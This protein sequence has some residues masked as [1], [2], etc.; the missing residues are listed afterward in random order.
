[1]AP[2]ASHPEKAAIKNASSSSAASFRA[3]VTASFASV[4]AAAA[5]VAA[6][7]AALAAAVVDP[8]DDDDDDATERPPL[9]TLAAPRERAASSGGIFPKGDR[10]GGRRAFA[11][12][13]SFDDPA[14]ADSGGVGL[15]AA[16]AAAAADADADAAAEDTVT[17]LAERRKP[18]MSIHCKGGQELRPSH[19]CP[20]SCIVFFI[21]GSG[22]VFE[23]ESQAS[24]VGYGGA[25]YVFFGVPTISNLT[26]CFLNDT[27]GRVHAEARRRRRPRN[28]NSFKLLLDNNS[29]LTTQ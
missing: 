7:A 29:K 3:P 10:D 5:V 11:V 27:V 8:D 14:V 28:D 13:P 16:A 25:T 6:A 24:Y 22:F 1:M 17:A 15:C 12:A 18:W 19:C 9:T 26:L 23:R 4:T 20:E 2:E 21:G